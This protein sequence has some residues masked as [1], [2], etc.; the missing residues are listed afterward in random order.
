MMLA[1]LF[2]AVSAAAT[3]LFDHVIDWRIR[4]DPRE[5]LLWDRDKKQFP[6]F[7]LG[8][9]VL[10][11]SFVDSMDQSVDHVLERMTGKRVFNGSITGA[12]PP[13]FI[14]AGRLLVHDGVRHAVVVV[15]FMP[16]RFFE[17]RH[18]DPP[19]G[20]YP[21][22]FAR[23]LGD[24]SVSQGFI[25]LVRPLTI[26]N[27][28]IM[29]DTA[30][31]KNTKQYGVGDS[32]DRVWNRDGNLGRNRFQR[33]EKEVLLSGRSRSFDW[34]VTLDAILKEGDNELIV[35]ITPVNSW[36]IEEYAHTHNASAYLDWLHQSREALIRDL[37]T[38][39]IRYIDGFGE[40]HSE[41]FADFV[42]GNARGDKNLAELISRYLVSHG[43]DDVQQ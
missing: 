28:D 8:D 10:V 12:D 36:M 29:I 14:N 21:G 31:Y 24:N 22:E 37:Q 20:S 4:Q 16:T 35:L 42:H 27:P 25:D 7:L 13:D 19:A 43:K 18:T 23:M 34:I 39:N 11:S 5:R 40:G 33:F 17:M 3:T 26:L 15:D 1:V 38:K 2:Y 30:V 6:I 41:D 9:S 32:R